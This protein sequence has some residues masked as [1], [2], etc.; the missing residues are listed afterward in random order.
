MGEYE[1]SIH[2]QLEKTHLYSNPARWWSVGDD[3]KDKITNILLAI[4][5][6]INEN[7]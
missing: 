6:T 3:V 4:V 1:G 5:S 2:I 7:K